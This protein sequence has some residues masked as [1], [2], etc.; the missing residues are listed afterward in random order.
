[1]KP[2]ESVQKLLKELLDELLDKVADLTSCNQSGAEPGNSVPPN[3]HS[4]DSSESEHLLDT[5]TESTRSLDHPDL[6]DSLGN[7]NFN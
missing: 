2:K 5:S 3:E 7:P 4:E 1:M 6:S